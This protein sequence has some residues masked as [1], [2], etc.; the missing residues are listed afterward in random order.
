[1]PDLQVPFANI[2]EILGEFIRDVKHLGF[3]EITPCPFGQACVKLNSPFDR[4]ALVNQ[5]PH[6]FGDVHVIFQKHNQGIN[7][8][9]LAMNGEN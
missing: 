7:W 8:R 6:A 9:G 4:D 1:M 5:S 2:R 3:S